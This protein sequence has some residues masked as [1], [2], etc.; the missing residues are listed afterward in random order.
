MS[1][2]FALDGDMCLTISGRHLKERVGIVNSSKEG[3]PNHWLWKHK[4]MHSHAARDPDGFSCGWLG[5]YHAQ[6]PMHPSAGSSFPWSRGG[7]AG[8]VRVPHSHQ[9]KVCALASATDEAKWIHSYICWELNLPEPRAES[10]GVT[11]PLTQTEISP[12][13]NAGLSLCGAP[14]PSVG[15]TRMWH[16]LRDRHPRERERQRMSKAC[17]WILDCAPSSF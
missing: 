5:Y 9:F 17:C 7:S 1:C 4:Y 13:A 6:L 16:S 8:H 3:Y 2:T 15:P 11:I 12:N 10:V 14:V